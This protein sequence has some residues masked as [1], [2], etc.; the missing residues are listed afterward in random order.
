MLRIVKT[1]ENFL[2]TASTP[3]W[4][5]MD[6]VLVIVQRSLSQLRNPT[7]PPSGNESAA[8]ERRTGVFGA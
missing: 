3:L 4:C 7:L 5:S 6:S 2:Q 1:E 8:L